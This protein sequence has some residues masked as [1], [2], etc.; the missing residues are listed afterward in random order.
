M[1]GQIHIFVVLKKE[2]SAYTIYMVQSASVAKWA[3]SNRCNQIRYQL[4]QKHRTSFL[5]ISSISKNKEFPSL[6][7][8]ISYCLQNKIS[9]YIL[10]WNKCFNVKK[11]TYKRSKWIC[12][13]PC[14]KC[15]IYSLPLSD[16][17]PYQP[18]LHTLSEIYVYLNLCHIVIY[19]I[20]YNYSL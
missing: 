10:K 5:N 3:R 6:R 4:Q 20:F 12:I 19:N 16:N 18:Y 8:W 7:C 13:F 14:P 11:W 2:G 1:G 15:S 9:L 17:Q